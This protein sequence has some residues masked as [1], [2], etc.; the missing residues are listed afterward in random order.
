[1]TKYGNRHTAFL[2]INDPPDKKPATIDIGKHLMFNKELGI[3]EHGLH[4]AARQLR[5]GNMVVGRLGNPSSP[6]AHLKSTRS[7]GQEAYIE[8]A[9]G[10]KYW[11]RAMTYEEYCFLEKKG[12][13]NLE[14]ATLPLSNNALVLSPKNKLQ[15]LQSAP[16]RHGQPT[17]VVEDADKTDNG[18]LGIA[19]HAGYSRPYMGN[20]RTHNWLVEFSDHDGK[21]YDNIMELKGKAGKP[22]AIKGEGGGTIGLG[23]AG[24][25]PQGECGS[26]FNKMLMKGEIDFALI[27]VIIS[28]EGIGGK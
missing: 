5:S 13:L 22:P 24:S 2:N 10:L 25:L 27:E 1:M 16:T 18:F 26:V 15:R 11:Y 8:I 4:A 14:P 7:V 3:N 17:P 28:T 21:V 6:V 12:V 20:K 19:T 23:N 9:S